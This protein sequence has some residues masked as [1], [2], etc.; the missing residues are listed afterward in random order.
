MSTA[1]TEAKPIPK[2]RWLRIIPPMIIIYIIAYMDRMNIS[3]AMAGGMNQ[4]LGITATVSGLAAGIFFAGYLVLQIHG[5][6][7]AE[8]GS[9]KKF[10]FWTIIGWGGTS[11]LTGFVQNG[12]QLLAMRFLLGVAEGG[13]W[14]A[15]LVSISNWFPEEE[16]G[17]ANAFFMSSLALAAVVTSPLTGWI[18]GVF[19][20]RYVFF[21]EGAISLA[22]IFVWLPLFADRPEEAKWI[23]KEEKE[24]LAGRLR[25]EREG[26]KHR[27]KVAVS[28]KQLLADC[29]LWK[30]TLIYFCNQVGQYGFLLW[31]PTILKGLT[32]VGMTKIGFLAA[33]P[34]L[35][36]LPGLYIFSVLADKRMNRRLW[37]CLTECGFALFCLLAALFSN[38]IWLSYSF[39]VMTGMFTKAPAAIFWVLPRTLFQPGVSGTA[40][41]FINAVG[42]LGGLVGPFLVGWMST[43]FSMKAGMFC[44]VGF[45]FA[46]GFLALTLPDITA[47]VKSPVDLKRESVGAR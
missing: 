43:L 11:I 25:S 28:Y 34:Y 10:I 21:I 18:V 1:N 2:D 33:A 15:I 45:L 47:G 12:W 32:K 44:L 3:F 29:N 38:H 8:H 24:Y 40:R 4:A 37:T 5:G 7:I 31:L 42:C 22:L 16:C 27:D 35:V 19:S 46:G 17:R 36:A 20:W 14:P 6:H 41:G 9:A 23:S 13:I 26:F 39:I 30:L